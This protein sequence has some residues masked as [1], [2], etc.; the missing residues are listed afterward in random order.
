M[1]DKTSLETLEDIKR[2]M[3]RSSRFISLSGLSGVSAGVS[4]L[5][6][7]WIA[8][9][10]LKKPYNFYLD[11]G[12]HSGPE[13]MNVVMKLIILAFAVFSYCIDFFSVF[14]LEQGEKK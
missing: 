14:H 6:G 4:A 8:D 5:I 11:S 3:E 13:F 9:T 2:I 10:W 1:D 12:S 7:A